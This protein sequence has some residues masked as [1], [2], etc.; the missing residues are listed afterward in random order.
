MH[1]DPAI[2]NRELEESEEFFVALIKGFRKRAAAAKTQ[3]L[4][5]DLEALSQH[6][7]LE[8]TQTLIWA[9]REL[10]FFP[11]PEIINWFRE[12]GIKK[13]RL[14]RFIPIEDIQREI[15]LIT[16]DGKV[17]MPKGRILFLIKVHLDVQIANEVLHWVEF[18]APLNGKPAVSKIKAEFYKMFRRRRYA[19]GSPRL[20]KN[21]MDRDLHRMIDLFEK[22]MGSKKE[23]ETDLLDFVGGNTDTILFKSIRALSKFENKSKYKRRFMP[24]IKLLSTHHSVLSKEEHDH[25]PRY[26]GRSYEVYLARRFDQL[27]R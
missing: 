19:K 25:Q 20:F 24:L 12:A 16:G 10:A 9:Y 1:Y 18:T 6:S 17:W 14:T 22:Q 5:A 26:Y 4:S 11:D 15:N 27:T 21:E 8:I 7:Y 23:T 2:H 3:L 13:H